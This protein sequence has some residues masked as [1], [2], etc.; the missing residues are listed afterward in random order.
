[1]FQ[2]FATVLVVMVTKMSSLTAQSAGPEFQSAPI[3][4]LIQTQNPR[5]QT[6]SHMWPPPPPQVSGSRPPSPSNSF[7]HLNTRN[8]RPPGTLELPSHQFISNERPTGYLATS[9]N[10]HRNKKPP[11]GHPSH[12]NP[13]GLLDGS[14][15]FISP[16]RAPGLL[17][18]PSKYPS[19]QRPSGVLNTHPQSIRDN[20]NT[21]H[22]NFHHLSQNQNSAI[23][24]SIFNT[25]T[26]ISN[27]RP[28]TFS[29]TST[30]ESIHVPQTHR[31]QQF[32]ISNQVL[33]TGNKQVGINLNPGSSLQNHNLDNV[34]PN[35][36]NY[37]PN[38]FQGNS[39]AN[40]QKEKQTFSIA[41]SKP[42]S[43]PASTQQFSDFEPHKIKSVRNQTSYNAEPSVQFSQS[44]QASEH[45]STYH[46]AALFDQP[47][48]AITLTQGPDLGGSYSTNY[49][50][51]TIAPEVK[52]KLTLK[53]ILAEDCPNAK[54]M[55][56]CA[57]PPRYPA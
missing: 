26:D 3:R 25:Q 50:R 24:N 4:N 20:I 30:S 46:P 19:F 41:N 51:T 39:V 8:Q 7:P 54:E 49:V 42:T 47:F 9:S 32:H 6:L 37:F 13:P 56:Y 2:L 18:D 5:V 35:I 27:R 48:S 57:S 43:F 34:V 14:P 10:P 55:G 22:S 28:Q 45:H 16:Q 40:V 33:P 15:S 1:M 44:I 11:V 52:K 21:I 12:Q 23:G 31:D 53:D 38:N 36:N 29:D 17:E